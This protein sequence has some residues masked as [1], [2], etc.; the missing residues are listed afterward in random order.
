MNYEKMSREEL[1]ATLVSMVAA[2]STEAAQAEDAV[3]LFH[4]LQVHQIELEVQ[5]HEL[6]EARRELEES[7]DRYAE[8]YELAPVPYFS[9]DEQGVV[10]DL[11][12][13]ASDFLGAERD[14]ILGRPITNFLK[15]SEPSVFWQHLGRC[16]ESGQPVVSEFRLRVGD[17]TCDVEATSVA[18]SSTEA[19]LK[20]KTVRT[21]FADITGHKQIEAELAIACA[22][23]QGLRAQIEAI[24]RA[25]SE[26]SSALA[27]A[28]EHRV[29][30]VVQTI[31]RHAM[32]LTNAH[33]A[34]LQ[35]VDGVEFGP[36]MPRRF[37]SGEAVAVPCAHFYTPLAF[38]GQQLAVLTI[39][40][41]QSLGPDA[42]A[43][44][45]TLAMYGERIASALEVARLQ[46]L[47]CRERERLAT[48]EQ[49]T[50]DLETA[51]T[52]TEVERALGSVARHT[53][54]S[55]ARACTVHLCRGEQ[56]KLVGCQHVDSAHQ[57][58]F[59]ATLLKPRAELEQALRKL[60]ELDEPQAF[61]LLPSEK[62]GPSPLTETNRR[63]LGE[64]FGGQL[65][66]VTPLSSR[67]RALG[68]MCFV[69]KLETASNGHEDTP[70]APQRERRDDALARARAIAAR[71]AAALNINQLVA[72]LQEAVRWRESVMA[73]V[74]HDLRGPLNTIALSANAITEGRQHT[75]KACGEKHVDLIRRSVAHMDDM[76]NDLVTMSALESGTFQ[77]DAR[78]L[79][80]R[81][82]MR[83][84]CDVAEP[85][86]RAR[87][88]RLECATSPLPAL[89]AD[90]TRILRVFG[91]LI[92]NAIKYTPSG[93]TIRVEGSWLGDRV[94]F[95]VSDS[96]SGIPELDRGKIFERFWRRNLRE[97][98]LGLGLYIAR[99]IVESHGGTIW[100]ETASLGG[101][102]FCFEL[103]A[104]SD[105]VFAG[106]R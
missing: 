62:G 1:V 76:I 58:R 55:V 91:N 47:D 30:Q 12:R 73:A 13:C 70:H 9:I 43:V 97:H 2:H 86:A 23:E 87:S 89:V 28:R 26:V 99:S 60:A 50:R 25:H 11:N 49:I 22:A 59:E 53:V 51:Q 36:E 21:T 103:P 94:R 56:L 20:P 100:V 29:G 6:R 8:L 84:A 69:H 31:L 83:E 5:N 46:T 64:V 40:P 16:A 75:E 93:G 14:R 52:V 81:D 92:G 78:Q 54:P 67:G 66:V 79:S 104:R 18:T 27:A 101:A 88:I 4:D 77:V 65:L 80:A 57:P 68:V 34:D 33:R 37:S 102:K 90:R 42:A 32:T 41:A 10:R 48:L 44:E 15:F 63:A 35:F 105:E 19:A 74:S 106:M 95:S 17:R 3:R 96:G 24:D 71:C 85:L 98:G 38:A 82:L 72:E 7:R 39:Y 45:R 61:P